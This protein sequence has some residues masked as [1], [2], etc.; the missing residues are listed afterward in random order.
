LSHS[1]QFRTEVLIRNQGDRQVIKCCGR[2]YQKLHFVRQLFLF[3]VFSA[4]NDA[5]AVDLSSLDFLKE[6]FHMAGSYDWNS[7]D[8]TQFPGKLCFMLLN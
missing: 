5:G 6:S 3:V 7:V 2:W 8:L 4:G 1:N